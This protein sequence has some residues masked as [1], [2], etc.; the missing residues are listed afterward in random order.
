MKYPLFFIAIVLFSLN[1]NAQV[2]GSFTVGGDVTKFYPVTFS[3]GGWP[4][5]ATSELEL[6]RSSIH[7]DA[8]WRGSLFARFTYHTT[9][10]G[11]ASSFIDAEV[12]QKYNGD[13]LVNI[14]FVAGWRDATGL[15]AEDDIIVWLKGGGTTYY[16]RS[17]YAISVVVYDGVASPLPY[18]EVSGP[19][20]TFKTAID[21]YV[22]SYGVTKS[23]AA[24]FHGL[25]NNFFNGNVGIGT[26]DTKG[27]K[28]AVNGSMI[29]ESVKV[30]LYATWPDYVF[31]REYK[32][33]SLKET[34]EFI[35]DNGH[36][37]GMPSATEVKANGID[38]ADMDTRLL[39][40]IEELTLHLIKQDSSIAALQE[41]NKK[42]LHEM[43]KSKTKQ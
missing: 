22:N 28:L 37:P 31:A 13:A 29:A 12:M 19:A 26:I 25:N 43:K 14:E 3:D 16:Y 39:K 4:Q 30:K 10:W 23:G 36:L 15:N 34:K 41:E 6:G 20:H 42:L 1:T 38:V 18:Q 35:K 40:K 33:P 21:S 2:T 27:Y 17:K 11:N 7:T 24:Y 9:R 5:N 32:L 8:N